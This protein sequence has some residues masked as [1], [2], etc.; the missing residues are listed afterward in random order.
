MA[1]WGRGL[2]LGT[3]L[4]STMVVWIV[5]LLDHHSFGA[6]MFTVSPSVWWLAYGVFVGSLVGQERLAYRLGPKVWLAVHCCSAAAVYLLAP[7]QGFTAICLVTSAVSAAFVLGGHCLYVVGAQSAVIAVGQL[8]QPLMGAISTTAVFAGFQFFAA[9]MAVIAEREARTREELEETQWR[10]R[11]ATKAGERLRIARELHDLV[12]HQ[13]T[14]LTLE[15]EVA[16]HTT[17]GDAADHVDRARGT[18]K[19]LLASVRRA[20]SSLRTSQAEVSTAFGAISAVAKPE[21]RLDIADDLEFADPVLAN[22]VVRCVQ[23]IVT[24]A[25]R[26]ADA[27]HLRITITEDGPEIV[28]AAE[29]DGGG[30]ATVRQGNGLTGMRERL[31]AAGGALS[32]DTAPGKGFRLTARLPS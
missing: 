9:S 21:V 16:A 10:L 7:H 22:T 31:T 8:G 15:L 26:H 27:D 29:D 5:V 19:D 18:A 4:V 11:A 32:Y 24:N 30:A 3:A 12:G 28:I 17:H 25:V 13:L 2:R 14:A 23:E 1:L 6:A 20:V